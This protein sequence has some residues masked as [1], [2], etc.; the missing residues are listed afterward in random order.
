M[1][2]TIPRLRKAA[3]FVSIIFAQ[4]LA[5]CVSPPSVIDLSASTY[6]VGSKTKELRAA[7]SKIDVRNL[8]T[9]GE[10]SFGTL[11]NRSVFTIVPATPTKQTVEDDL[12]SFLG[13][14]TSIDT[15]ATRSIV[16]SILRADS[17]WVND[18]AGSIPFVG[19][20]LVGADKEFG[21]NLRLQIE[22][23]SNGKVVSTY[24]YE[25]VIKI[26]GKAT[27]RADID[28]SYQLL[29]AEYRRRLFNELE[30][31]FLTRYL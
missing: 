25:D 12:R 29:V 3:L 9:N 20:A 27:M 30:S 23:E 11:G 19:L 4:L 24:Q 2:Q 15:S 17:Y 31:R 5:G 28:N 21:M 1:I 7:I 8:A 18:V 6:E 14:A 26:P 13:Q 10:N 22:V 16:V